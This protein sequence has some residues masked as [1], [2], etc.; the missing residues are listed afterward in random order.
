MV[1]FC[2]VA[3]RARGRVKRQSAFNHVTFSSAGYRQYLTGAVNQVI[4]F[5]GANQVLQFAHDAIMF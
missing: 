5:F 2:K 3:N 1:C 4:Q